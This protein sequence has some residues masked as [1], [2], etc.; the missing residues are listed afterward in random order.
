MD[1]L[2]FIGLMLILGFW[3][4]KLSNRIKLPSVVGYLV[5][6][7]LL[8]P[9]FLNI[10]SLDLIDNLGVLNDLALAVVAFVIG[11]EMR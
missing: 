1:V 9:S 11:S 10:F 6:G 2:V 5:A 4:G 8:G 3:G 7:L